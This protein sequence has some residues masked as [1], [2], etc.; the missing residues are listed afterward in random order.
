MLG[1]TLVLFK[2]DVYLELRKGRLR[3]D[4]PGSLLGKYRPGVNEGLRRFWSSIVLFKVDVYI[5]LRMGR[6]R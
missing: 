6:F 5:E 2:V 3:R 4:N 1:V